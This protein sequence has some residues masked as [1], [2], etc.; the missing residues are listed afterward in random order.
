MTLDLEQRLDAWAGEARIVGS[1][2]RTPNFH[3][4]AVPRRSYRLLLSA[5]ITVTAALIGF[6]V[7]LGVGAGGKGGVQTLKGA[8]PTPTASAAIP[9]PE[10]PEVVTPLGSKYDISDVGTKRVDLGMAPATANTIVLSFTCLTAGTF[11]FPGGSALACSQ[12]D[13]QHTDAARTTTFHLPVTAGPQTTTVTAAAGTRWHLTA[14]YA[15]VQP[16]KW[17]TNAS[18]Q[19]YGAEGTLGIPDLVSV[20][21][22]NGRSGYA[23]A[24]QLQ[25]APYTSPSE[26]LAGQKKQ[27][28]RSVPVY[29]SDGKTVIGE[30]HMG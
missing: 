12:Q 24:T 3:D 6:A 1:P 18:G 28:P 4:P 15:N 25:G 30:F 9:V 20:V 29:T 22:T 13:L 14:T 23:Y 7:Y 2:P 11:S 19:T 8:T 10:V 16:A 26:A 27:K 21:A 17:G 5:G